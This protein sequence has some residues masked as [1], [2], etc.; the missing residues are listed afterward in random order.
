MRAGT[1]ALTTGGEVPRLTVRVYNYARLNMAS[2]R[3]AEEVAGTIFAVAGVGVNWVDCPLSQFQDAAYPACQAAATPTDIDL[4]ILPRR[5]AVKLRMRDEPLGFALPCS[6]SDP[7]CEVTI[8]DYMVD[9]LATYGYRADAILGHAIAHEMAHVLIGGGHT[10]DG[11]MR[12]QWSQPELQRMSWGLL[13]YF[14]DDQ[15]AALRAAAIR[16]QMAGR[17][18]QEEPSVGRVDLAGGAK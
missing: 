12:G 11:I 3:S 6:D 7:A 15:S 2:L 18:A 14:S 5:M 4:K 8:L 16:R 1:D 13:L 10:P 17:I 9:E